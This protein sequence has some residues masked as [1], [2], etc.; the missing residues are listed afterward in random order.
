MKTARKIRELLWAVM[1]IT[2][3]YL[4]AFP[5]AADSTPASH[6]AL[7]LQAAPNFRHAR[8]FIEIFSKLPS[9]AEMGAIQNYECEA[10]GGFWHSFRI[11]GCQGG[12]YND[13]ILSDHEAFVPDNDHI[14]DYNDHYLPYPE[15]P[16]HSGDECA[17]RGSAKCQLTGVKGGNFGLRLKLEV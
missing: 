6:P 4:T 13:H 10:E 16:L 5:A 14:L 2:L 12:D 7:F 8:H 1:A 9:S 11:R 17:I 3:G 15:Y